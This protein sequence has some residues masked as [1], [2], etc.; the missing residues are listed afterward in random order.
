M[1]KPTT[2]T[3]ISSK[4]DDSVVNLENDV[5]DALI[6]T[7]S[8]KK[9]VDCNKAAEELLGFT[10]KEIKGKKLHSIL[11]GRISRKKDIQ[12]TIKTKNGQELIA[13]VSISELK[14][15][16]KNPTGLVVRL[17]NINNQV[18][19]ED[20]Y[21]VLAINSPVG[22]AILQD[23]KFRYVNHLLQNTTGFDDTELLNI[24]PLTF[25]HP[26]DRETVTQIINNQLKGIPSNCEFRMVTKTGAIRWTLGNFAPIDFTG[27]PAILVTFT[28]M[29]DHK[30]MEDSLRQ[31][32]EHFKS[33]IENS[34]DVIMVLN[35]DGTIRYRS[36]SHERMFGFTTD[37]LIGKSAFDQIH[38][39]DFKRITDIF[40]HGL[41]I[42]GFTANLEL[43]I[44]HKDG[45]WR[46]IE[47]TG[48]NLLDNPSVQ[49]IILN[50]SD[51][52]DRKK[53]EEALRESEEKY[54]FIAENI[55]D[56]I[57]MADAEGNYTYVN[58]AHRKIGGYDPE[59]LIGKS[60][61]DYLHPEDN[62]LL[63]NAFTEAEKKDE[64]FE[65]R[66]K[67]KD[68][69][70]K[71]I[72]LRGNLITNEAGDL[73]KVIVIANDISERR[74]WEEALRESEQ[75]F[76]TI[77][78]SANDGIVYL[79]KFG[80]VVDLNKRT[81]S[82]LGFGY[83]EIIG[84]NFVEIGFLR[85]KDLPQIIEYFDSSITASK[86][87]GMMEI[88]AI[89][90]DGRSVLI[91]TSASMISKDGELEGMLVLLR[92][93]TGRKKSEKL[94]RIQR[95]LAQSLSEVSELYEGLRLCTQAALQ[96]S[97]MD[98]GGIYLVDKDTGS[99][100]LAFHVGLSDD[101]IKRSSHYEANSPNTQL[102]MEGAAIYADHLSLGLSI[103]DPKRNEGLHA[104]AIVPFQHDGHVVG[105]LNV[106]SHSTLEVPNF[107]RDALELIAV[108]IGSSIA[109]LNA[110]DALKQS[111][112]RFRT[113]FE[114]AND[115]IIYLDAGGTII[116]RNKDEDSI[117]GYSFKEVIGKNITE[118]DFMLPQ[119]KMPEMEGLLGSVMEGEHGGRGVILH[120]IAHKDGTIAHVESSI[121]PLEKN[122]ENIGLLVIYRDITDRFHAQDTISRQAR[123]LS[124]RFQEL[125]CVYGI[126]KL[127][128]N[129]DTSLEELI[130]ATVNLIP[131]AWQYSEITCARVIYEDEIFTTGDFE[132]SKWRQLS[133]VLVNGKR[134]GI[135]E[136]CYLE[137]KP[138]VYEGP[139]LKEERELLDTL[140]EQ[141][142]LFIEHK[143]AEQKIQQQYNSIQVHSYEVQVA[144]EE[145]QETQQKLLESNAQLQKAI[146][147][148][149]SSQEQLIQS[150]KL[151][152]VGKLASGIAHEVN[153]P[154]MAIS[155][156]AQMLIEDEDDELIIESLE[157]IHGE[158]RRATDIIQNLLSFSRQQKT[159]KKPI[160]I[161]ESIESTLKLL[162]Y[163]LNKN[164]IEAV[165]QF[166]TDL[167]DITVDSQQMRQ[168]FLNL[169]NNAS[170]AMSEAHGSGILTI[171]TY[172]SGDNTV[173]VKFT[174]DG[175]GIPPD[176]IDKIFE[177]FYTTKDIGK[178]T[179]L[180]L[181]WYNPEPRR[182]YLCHK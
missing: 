159:F 3:Y 32:V 129:P 80:T 108:E 95:D 60:T 27:K 30:Q 53:A 164:N 17:K 35:A 166:A 2:K 131:Y 154:L 105:C 22:I 176:V 55:N 115:E 179:G 59:E 19:E 57:A 77:F 25:I 18:P 70:Y 143:L 141:L 45:S 85:Q 126:S 67:C 155:G 12:R 124:K 62:E 181:L 87:F 88:E 37:E 149:Q 134:K 151:A 23:S 125:H 52:I 180:H 73:E 163:V 68:G 21:K 92:D 106:A 119:N 121:S 140:A 174:D 98:C 170:Q 168:V 89:R 31:S 4:W 120:E 139:F 162:V 83:D 43:R 157:I 51:I 1:P 100:N 42:P 173:I 113:I 118:L 9:I 135:V 86:A 137:E 46:D 161:N 94:T 8:S 78:Q 132:E 144:N 171:Q 14:D 13:G 133:V 40:A 61:F 64:T 102:I 117:T 104:V 58:E 49:G 128:Q 47:L 48:R 76:R 56:L 153:N 110:Q 91:E 7:N 72:H 178:G 74:N 65:V 142:G 5:D 97:D 36:P 50:Y 167:P 103:D 44:R 16:Q 147:D 172:K 34:S 148:L 130:Q 33:L 66:Y 182:Q 114:N 146:E 111:E 145:L 75:R 109:R 165:T 99:L 82:I 24:D 101:F 6:W 175:P 81:E 127:A 29:D 158:T 96:A 90:K 169:I 71:W 123:D 150:E 152:A 26:D 39:A 112:E 79:D 136:V 41:E 63:A 93:V 69:S 20:I 156:H 84:M 11:P 10:Q 160:S 28:D 177:P 54:R 15:G 38:P 138:E 107:S 122:G 116:A